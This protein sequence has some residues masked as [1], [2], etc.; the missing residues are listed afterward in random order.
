MVVSTS[1]IER[2]WYDRPTGAG[3]SVVVV[4]T[5]SKP[6]TIPVSSFIETT[7]EA[8]GLAL[9]VGLIVGVG[10]GTTDGLGEG[11][12]AGVG[13]GIG[14]GE[15]E[16]IGLGS[17]L[18]AGDGDTCGAGSSEVDTYT[19]KA[20]PMATRAA[21]IASNKVFNLSVILVLSFLFSN[22]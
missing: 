21:E 5:N 13:D 9:G 19:V 22:P 8:D 16:A 10:L 7:G 12:A 1:V 14:D 20:T 3:G 11:D 15:T 2:S 6:S 18:G 4:A 17:T